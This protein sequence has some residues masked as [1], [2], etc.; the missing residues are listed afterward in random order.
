VL[1]GFVLEYRMASDDGQLV[2]GFQVTEGAILAPNV[3]AYI[4]AGDVIF[5]ADVFRRFGADGD[6]DVGPLAVVENDGNVVADLALAGIVDGDLVGGDRENSELLSDE[7]RKKAGDGCPGLA[8]LM[9]IGAFIEAYALPHLWR[10]ALTGS[11]AIVLRA[12]RRLVMAAQ[13]LQH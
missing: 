10:Y 3:L 5:H 7:G 9:A 1:P 13:A 2:G 8:A 12:E 4:E 6:F 11:G